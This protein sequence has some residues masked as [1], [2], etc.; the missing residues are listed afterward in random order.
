[1]DLDSE[2]MKEG[3]GKTKGKGKNHH[4]AL[5]DYEIL[6]IPLQIPKTQENRG[7]E[8]QYYCMLHPR[9]ILGTLNT[10]YLS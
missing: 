8:N 4:W 6:T 3:K 5:R 10:Q 2:K 9:H 7:G 1:M